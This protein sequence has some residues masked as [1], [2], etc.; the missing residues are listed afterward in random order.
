MDVLL[1]LESLNGSHERVGKVSASAVDGSGEVAKV[2]LCGAIEE[3]LIGHMARIKDEV[4]SSVMRR[5]PI[6]GLDMV[7][8]Q[9]FDSALQRSFDAL[10]S[11]LDSELKTSP[12][13]DT[14]GGVSDSAV[15]QPENFDLHADIY[16]Q[17]RKT[18][19]K[20]VEYSKRF[21][22]IPTVDVDTQSDHEDNIVDVKIVEEYQEKIEE[23]QKK[24]DKLVLAIKVRDRK[25]SEL[26]N[27]VNRLREALKLMEKQAYSPFL[28]A[29]TPGSQEEILLQRQMQ[30][31]MEFMRKITPILKRDPKYK[32]LFYLKRVGKIDFGKLSQDLSIPPE[33]LNTLLE[34]LEAMNV[35]KMSGD[36]VQLR[37]VY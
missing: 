27:E 33:K 17:M 32:I 20:I 6:K 22:E 9:A 34:E 4:V 36:K 10:F 16:S 26:K 3:K 2:D 31:L 15:G 11:V 21:S 29:L 30:G 8:R 25:I 19:G 1:E 14:L 23:Y 5:F 28:P 37:D 24:I 13:P 18:I 12:L 35:V 7:I